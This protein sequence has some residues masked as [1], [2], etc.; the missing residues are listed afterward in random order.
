M[1][2]FLTRLLKKKYSREYK[3]LRDINISSWPSLK[4]NY[5]GITKCGN[6]KIRSHLYKL[7]TGSEY[8]V[9]PVFEHEHV[10][11]LTRDQ[12]FASE[13]QN[14][15]VTRHPLHRFVS[16][17]KDLCR[18]RPKRG[19]SAGLQPSWSLVQLARWVHEMPDEIVDIHFKSQSWFIPQP[20]EFEID[21]SNINRDWP[22]DLPAPTRKR[23]RPSNQVDH[24]IDD[25]TKKLIS[26][27][28]AQDLERFGYPA[29]PFS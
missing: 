15:T 27:R 23:V 25:E 14:F 26:S 6:T 7:S 21:L 5:W 2:S 10:S 24:E 17:W 1:R 28:Y 13:R 12:A 18:T 3:V 9:S 29:D 22:F 20:L 4:L 16:A 8:Q 19:V 11:F